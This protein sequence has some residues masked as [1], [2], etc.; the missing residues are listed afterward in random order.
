MS[1]DILTLCTEKNFSV[2]ALVVRN[3]PADARDTGNVD[4][5][6]G[7]GRSPGG[8][9]GDPHQYSCLENPMSK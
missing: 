8:G 3:M 2:V 6:H 1:L 4:L 7:P 5:T 9:H